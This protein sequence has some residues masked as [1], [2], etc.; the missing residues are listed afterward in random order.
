[1]AKTIHGERLPR[2]IGKGTGPKRTLPQKI[3]VARKII[4]M[5]R[6]GVYALE[7]CCNHYRVSLATFYR[8]AA[9]ATPLGD[10]MLKQKP[11]PKGA[12]PTIQEMFLEAREIALGNYRHQVKMLAYDKLKDKIEGEHYEETVCE[13]ALDTNLYI[14]DENNVQIPNP[15]FGKQILVGK[16]VKTGRRASDTTLIRDVLF[17][18]DS[19]NFQNGKVV[20]TTSN[21]EISV[22][23]VN[24]MTLDE[25]A[26]EKLAVRR[27]LES[28]GVNV[29]DVDYEEVK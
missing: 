2:P 7:Y 28:L 12:V 23:N 1:M 22:R 26:A 3:E 19:E 9:P 20:Q 25:I 13:Y 18:L 17:N 4:E 15:N 21:V 14:L 29:T 8:W 11:L 27:R 5:F 6:T 24:K 10:L 16:K